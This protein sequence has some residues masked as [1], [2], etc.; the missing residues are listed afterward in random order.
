MVDI[1]QTVSFFIDY[2][3]LLIL[4]IREDNLMFN[5]ERMK[6]YNAF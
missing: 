2:L 4:Y 3:K 5:K 1:R 6:Y